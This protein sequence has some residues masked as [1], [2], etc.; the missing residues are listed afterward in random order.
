MSGHSKWSTIKR[1]KGAED[2]K[3]GQIFTRVVREISLAAREGG[4]DPDSNPRLRLAIDKA[5]AANMPKDN[6]E[7][8]INK[9]AGIGDDAVIYE[10]I[11]YEGYGPHGVAIIVDTLTDNRNRT[12][13]EVKH[14]FNKANG[15]LA[16]ANAVQWQFDQK[17][18]IEVS[19]E[20]ANFD[21]LF[22][23]AAEAGAEDVIE[24]EGTFI[25]YTVRE[26]LHEVEQAISAGG[27]RIEDSKL[28]WVPKNEVELEN[29]HAMSIIR[30]I[31]RL[32]ELDDV[33]NVSSNLSLSEANMA[34]FAEE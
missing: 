26:A 4:P 10:E 27:Y 28:T 34:A 12:L 1:K 30:L 17:G 2:A 18:Y 16:Q 23:L 9:G 20:G 15:T 33:Q 7:R 31:E 22:L 5:K 6:I 14:A 21:E 25:I 11:V 32:E 29:D 24:E 13:A 19:R 8:A 3:R